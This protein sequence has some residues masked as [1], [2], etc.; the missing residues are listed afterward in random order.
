VRKRELCSLTLCAALLT[1][2]PGV[3]AGCGGQEEKPSG[4]PSQTRLPGR[5][6]PDVLRTTLP[7]APGGTGDV[8]AAKKRV[9]ETPGS[10]QL[11]LLG[12]AYYKAGDYPSAVT[13]LTAAAA[14][15]PKQPGPV[16]YLAYSHVGAGDLVA[17]EAAFVRLTTF[18]LPEKDLARTYQEIGWCRWQARDAEAARGAFL[19]SLSYE[20]GNYW[21]SYRLGL[22]ESE[23]GDQA[24]AARHLG[25]AVRAA[26]SPVE[27]RAAEAALARISAA[28]MPSPTP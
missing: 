21:A 28:T 17:A 19:K 16:F 15:A 3:T 1:I 5:V 27:R 6:D 11:Y 10:R 23:R 20:P 24:E 9:G 8:P 4:S 13:Q 22:L 14:R 25:A 7:P 12:L 18:P 26:E 2:P